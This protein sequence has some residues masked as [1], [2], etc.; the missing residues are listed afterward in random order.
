MEALFTLVIRFFDFTIIFFKKIIARQQSIPKRLRSAVHLLRKDSHSAEKFSDSR[1]AEAL[2]ISSV[3]EFQKILNG[4]DEPSFSLLN[5]LCDTY[6]FNPA[7]VKHGGDN[8]PISLEDPPLYVDDSF[9]SQIVSSDPE[10]IYLVRCDD[11][12]ADVTIVLRGKNSDRFY[13]YPRVV[14][15][16]KHVGGTGKRQLHIFHSFLRRVFD[17]GLS[18][19]IIGRTIPHSDFNSLSDGQAYPEALLRN[20]QDRT[21]HWWDDFIFLYETKEKKASL[22][23]LYGQ[24]FVDAQDIVRDLKLSV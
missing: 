20:R 15:L 16:S 8:H 12:E 11:E 1:I 17:Q 24:S 5:K 22:L 3:G 18:A 13:V 21:I 7:W 10:Y 6:G 2:A 4:Q 9:L 19:S 14:R 23:S